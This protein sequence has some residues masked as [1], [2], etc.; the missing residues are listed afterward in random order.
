MRIFGFSQLCNHVRLFLVALLVGALLP[1]CSVLDKELTNRGGYIDYKLDKHWWVADTKQMR[2][3]RAYVLVGSVA[4]MAQ[5]K[6]QS[7][8]ESIVQQVNSAIR[9]MSDAFDCAYSQPGRCV[10]FDERMAEA[11]VAVLRLLVAVSTQKEDEDLFVGLNK[12]V[13]DTFPLL[14]GVD[15]LAKLVEAATSTV[16]FSANI[17]KII[18]SIIQIG[19]NAYFKGRRL[20]ALYRDSIELQMITVMSS[21]DTMCAI[22]TGIYKKYQTKEHRYVKG[23]EYF[24]KWPDRQWAIDN[25]YGAPEELPPNACNAFKKG[26]ALW[27]R[28]SGDLGLWTDF[29]ETDGAEFRKWLIPN[30]ETF[31]QASDLVWRACE[32]ITTDKSELS[33][34][35]GRR[36]SKEGPSATECAVD[37]DREPT[38]SAAKVADAVAN[39][40]G[41]NNDC[42]LILYAQTLD[43]R[44]ER[45]RRSGAAARLD[46]LS[47]LSPSPSHPLIEH[48]AQRY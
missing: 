20:G 27:N 10:Y 46:W 11:E 42:R 3:L 28:G 44:A 35:I 9:V 23:V 33:E 40:T 43:L 48:P 6:Y 32:H 38:K 37:F 31:I 21:L 2:V 4:R 15:S 47:E 17:P 45:R 36:R 29:L 39:K 5:T 13:G 8:R 7:E 18:H 26:F 19:Q 16:E 41:A 30:E 22:R 34:C 24:D 14:K 1:G 12:V 25:F